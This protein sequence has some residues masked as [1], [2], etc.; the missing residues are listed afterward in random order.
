MRVP[1]TPQCFMTAEQPHT[2][3]PPSTRAH[4]PA[5]HRQPPPTSDPGLLGGPAGDPVLE[6]MA[7]VARNAR[8]TEV[9]GRPVGSGGPGPGTLT[10]GVRTGVLRAE[11]GLRLRLPRASSA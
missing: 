11:P 5:R 10:A 9:A 4:S 7:E 1:A 6:Q 8:R 2:P 3:T